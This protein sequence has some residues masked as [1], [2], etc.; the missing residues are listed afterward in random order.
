MKE[1]LQR[2][3][4]LFLGLV[5]LWGFSG[6][7]D[8]DASS[9][10]GADFEPDVFG[11]PEPGFMPPLQPDFD[12]PEPEPE[13][14]EPLEPDT[15]PEAEPP[16]PDGEGNDQ[17]PGS[18]E[19]HWIVLDMVAQHIDETLLETETSFPYETRVDLSTRPDTIGTFAL[20]L[21]EVLH[22]NI[23]TPAF[24]QERAEELLL[25][26]VESLLVHINRE[27]LA[28][29]GLLPTM[30]FDGSSWRTHPGVAGREVLLGENAILSLSLASTAGSMLNVSEPTLRQVRIT[31]TI[32][33][34]LNHQKIGF[35]RFVDCDDSGSGGCKLRRAWDLQLQTWREH[36]GSHFELFGEENR[37]ALLFLA[38]RFELPLSIYSDLLI[39]VRPYETSDGEE[40]VVVATRD[41]GTSQMLGSR[42]LFPESKFPAMQ[43][44]HETY[45]RVALD[46]SRSRNLMGLVSACYDSPGNYVEHAG[47]SEISV[48]DE[49]QRNQQLASF[50]MV[51]VTWRMFPQEINEIMMPVRLIHDELTMAGVSFWEG[52]DEN[53]E[54]IVVQST[55]HALAL[56]LGMVG[57]GPEYTEAYLRHY[58]LW[59]QIERAY[60][61]GSGGEFLPTE[62]DSFTSQ[63]AEVVATDDGIEIKKDVFKEP[64]EVLVRREPMDVSGLH[65]NLQYRTA[66]GVPAFSIALLDRHGQAR[67]MV[68]TPASA[69]PGIYEFKA[70]LPP[71][72]GLQDIYGAVLRFEPQEG[73]AEEL[74]IELL[75]FGVE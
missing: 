43:R 18:G 7:A 55:R 33:T 62:E 38:A 15:P 1:R 53:E 9:A 19:T 75:R 11:T 60:A 71:S 49:P 23:Q 59:P 34:I 47:I 8:A 21:A 58:R 5:F 31:Q 65:L 66:L 16:E 54:P 17:D 73:F 41:G 4:L 26:L 68:W 27:E 22:G 12:P 45:A 6:C 48:R 67:A 40:L 61:Q 36:N 50:S 52:F 70:Q 25:N 35:R 46:F 63:S 2:P 10:A 37:A 57:R 39:E 3:V 20:F 32:E 72:P 14:E 13:P 28:F 24:S 64:V 69:E 74:Q 44:V 30:T 51:G 29:E 56:W 42:L